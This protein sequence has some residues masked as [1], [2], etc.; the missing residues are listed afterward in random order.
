MRPRRCLINAQPPHPWRAEA[1]FGLSGDLFIL[2]AFLL[3]LSPLLLPS[4]C[5]LGYQPQTPNLFFLFLGVNQAK[6]ARNKADKFLFLWRE[7]GNK[8]VKERNT[9]NNLFWWSSEPKGDNHQ[10]SRGVWGEGV[11]SRW[12]WRAPGW[13]WPMSWG[14]RGSSQVCK[15][16]GGEI[17]F[18]QALSFLLRIPGFVGPPI[19]GCGRSLKAG[20]CPLRRKGSCR[21]GWALLLWAQALSA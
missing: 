9:Q 6:T 1:Q 16:L 11:L 18:P 2:L 15:E 19:P 8:R 20:L 7:R 17:P 5:C 14:L 4:Q 3:S 10:D 13:R 21:T 12:A